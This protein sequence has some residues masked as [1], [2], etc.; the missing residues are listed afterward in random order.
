[1]DTD[2]D[3]GLALPSHMHKLLT[4]NDVADILGCGRTM[5]YELLGTGR[6]RHIKIGRL[7]RIPPSEIDR[8]I[9]GD[10]VGEDRSHA[11]SP[12]RSRRRVRTRAGA[13][14]LPLDG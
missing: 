11:G 2:E 9:S 5:V 6:L 12:A 4:V 7:T 1:M 13:L 3:A 14:L 8:L 10:P